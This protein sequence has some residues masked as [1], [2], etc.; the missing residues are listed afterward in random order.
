[1]KAVNAP[2][3]LISLWLLKD[4]IV[5]ERV[6]LRPL[7]GCHLCVPNLGRFKQNEIAENVAM[8]TT[9]KKGDW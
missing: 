4:V 5:P 1:M 7:S 9:G 2:L 3:Q 8:E 6:L